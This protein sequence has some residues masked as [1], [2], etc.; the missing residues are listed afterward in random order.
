[1]IKVDEKNRMLYF[2]ADGREASN[3]YFSQLCK[4]GFDGKNLVS[5]TPEDGN[6]SI[7]LSPSANY[8]TDSYS[9]PDLA[10]VAVFRNMDGKIISNIEKTDVTRLISSGWKAP[11]PVTLKAH[12]GKTDL[13]GL[14]FMPTNLDTV[15]IPRSIAWNRDEGQS[16][17]TGLHRLPAAGE[18]SEASALRDLY[19]PGSH[20]PGAE[21]RQPGTAGKPGQ[22]S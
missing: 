3:P 16:C 12:D 2:I 20:P 7:V 11:T 10:P 1:M 14:M 21:D 22:P 18:K 5:L 9:K 13:Y 15:L 6:H 4:I 19:A 8:F 17:R